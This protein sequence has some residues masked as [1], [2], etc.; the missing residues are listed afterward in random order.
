M[1]NLSASKQ[2]IRRE[3]VLISGASGFLASNLIKIMQNDERFMIYAL[4]RNTSNL[5]LKFNKVDNIEFITVDDLFKDRG[6]E[7]T[8]DTLIHT[9]FTLTS[10]L[11]KLTE[12]IIL[13]ER[14]FLWALKANIGTIINIS[15]KSVYD[16]A[17]KILKNESTIISPQTPYG[18][19]KY[20]TERLSNHILVSDRATSIRLASL[21]G[22]GFD[23]R[24]VSKMVKA[25]LTTQMIE[26][27][28]AYQVFSYLDVK[29]AADAIITMILSCKDKWQKVYNLGHYECYTMIEIASTIA[30]I[31]K[32]SYGLDIDIK[33]VEKD[34][35]VITR[36]D[37]NMFYHD[38]NWQPK[39]HLK[40][41]LIDIF[42]YYRKLD[43]IGGINND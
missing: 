31:A 11:S 33:V 20:Y 10:E 21:I 22:P 35:S 28:D 27:N 8:I 32:D 37:S 2:L 26:V 36:M 39:Y 1:K 38:F 5:R 7:L 13:S 24:M 43:Q 25:A 19:A 15:S 40:E 34:T 42:K 14:L 18:L 9:A 23:I 3:N 17:G 6:N 41:S 30:K 29:D 4:S 12:S 16:N